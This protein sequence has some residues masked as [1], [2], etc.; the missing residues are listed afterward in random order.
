MSTISE[1]SPLWG[2]WQIEKPIGSGTFGDVYLAKRY[3]TGREY[4]A[5][6]K[7]ISIPP[8][9][10]TIDALRAEGTVTDSASAQRYCESLL[11]VLTTEIDI[12]YQL[13]GHTNFVSYED[14]L[15]VPR[16]NEPGFDVFIRMELLTS[17]PDYTA[18]EGITVGSITKLCRDMCSAL[19]VLEK[20]NIIHRDIK[21]ANIFVSADGDFKLGDFGVARH[22][23][24]LGSVSVKGAY[25][26]MAPEILK[27]GLVGVSSD[28]YSLGIVLYRLLNYNRAPFLPPPPADVSYQDDQAA[29]DRRLSGAPL[30]PPARAE[31]SL[32]LTNVIMRACEYDPRARFSSASEMKSALE[33]FLRG[34]GESAVRRDLDATVAVDRSAVSGQFN[35]WSQGSGQGRSGYYPPELTKP[36]SP[37]DPPPLLYPGYQPEPV[38]PK[39]AD[40]SSKRLLFVLIAIIG[41]VIVMLAVILILI[42]P[43]RDSSGGAAIPTQQQGSSGPVDASSPP[44]SQ[45]SPVV[46]HEPVTNPDYEVFIDD[47]GSVY[48]AYPSHFLPN[49]DLKEGEVLSLSSPDGKT[50]MIVLQQNYAGAPMTELRE[51]YLA[52]TGGA[53]SYEAAG[54][55]WYAVSGYLGAVNERSF[56][57][58]AF[59][60]GQRLWCFDFYWET[61]E[62]YAYGD[63]VE[64]IEDHFE[65]HRV[66]ISGYEVPPDMDMGKM[67]VLK[68]TITS[69][70]RLKSVTV[71]VYNSSGEAETSKTVLT[72]GY[73]YD[74]SDDEMDDEIY[75]N[76]LSAGLKTYEVTAVDEVGESLLV[77]TTFRVIN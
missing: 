55:N 45:E 1:L 72:S 50:T 53:P 20:K 21:P 61:D 40:G 46:S 48:C 39:S 11:D 38:P 35:S 69:T 5:A 43:N 73:S 13:K 29:L 64:Y 54:S 77:R 28:L 70:H 49:S 19:E 52:M 59:V 47:T 41:A 65:P 15:I 8:K 58:K 60:D 26:Y 36:D 71:T 7:H 3:D 33:S 14:H 12:C 25:N 4:T 32:P 23:D 62:H 63:Y 37:R 76:Y 42:L 67:W 57:R 9:G 34:E 51:I 6:V 30:P 18:R 27:G 10:V 2:I 16:K 24:G 68:G 22:M 44:G 66:T 56:Y 17:L 75:F 74:L 31:L